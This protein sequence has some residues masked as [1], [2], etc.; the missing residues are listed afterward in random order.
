M[1]DFSQ[2]SKIRQDLLANAGYHFG[3]LPP[4]TNPDRF[5]IRLVER[6]AQRVAYVRVVGGYVAEKIMGGFDRLM[7]WGRR[8]DLVPDAQLIGISRDDPRDHT[9][10]EVSLRLVPRAA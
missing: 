2:D 10:E 5:R 8:H 3:K 1:S 4:T 6:P 9:D 7:E